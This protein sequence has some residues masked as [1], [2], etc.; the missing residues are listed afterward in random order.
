MNP[1]DEQDNSQL[2]DPLQTQ[3]DI[4]NP[5][6]DEEHLEE[7]NDSPAAPADD[8]PSPVIP[9]DHPATDDGVD[10]HDAYDEGIA[11]AAGLG[12]Q[13][14]G[15]DTRVTPVELDHEDDEPR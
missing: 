4:F 11:H 14:V 15:P 12:E 9:I 3:D 1:Q 7:D 8:V 13:T 6:H 2:P 10:E 5:Q